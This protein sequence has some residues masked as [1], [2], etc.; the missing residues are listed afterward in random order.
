MTVRKL[1]TV[2]TFWSIPVSVLG[3]LAAFIAFVVR[4]VTVEL[5][6][7]GFRGIVYQQGKVYLG[8]GEFHNVLVYDTFGNFMEVQNLVNTG[9]QFTFNVDDSGNCVG[10]RKVPLDIVDFPAE[11]GIFSYR[12][13]SRFPFHIQ[14]MSSDGKSAIRQPWYS[15][16]WFPPLW[17]LIAA[18][19][20]LLFCLLNLKK[21][22]EILLSK[23]GYKLKRILRELVFGR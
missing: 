15:M 9:R 22:S 20:L 16:L 5:P 11:G 3:F 10:Q 21:L 13:K 1:L 17:W 19:S 23:E 6:V 4:P 14:F 2:F 8:N 18:V 12:I 7:V